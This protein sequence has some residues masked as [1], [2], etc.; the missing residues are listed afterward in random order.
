V[1]AGFQRKFD[2]SIPMR[3]IPIFVFV[4]LF[5]CCNKDKFTT[6]PQLKYKSANIKTV[7]GNQVLQLKLDLT[8]KE[9]DF[10]TLLG[11][12]KTVSGCAASNYIDSTKFSIPDD[13]IKTKGTHG[14]V[15]LTLNKSDRGSNGC[16]VPGGGT[17]PDTT[18]FKF[19]TRD[20]AGNTSDT[21]FSE[22]IIILN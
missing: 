12:K 1:D 11:V 14:E 15:N 4:F 21:A 6:K 8:D 13:F 17:R 7:S 5:F 9:G 16:S 2:K 10:T 18:I 19:W 3:F 20:K 22:Q